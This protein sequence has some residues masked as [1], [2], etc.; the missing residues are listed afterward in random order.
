MTNIPPE[1]LAAAAIER[2]D[3]LNEELAGALTRVDALRGALREAIELIKFYH[4]PEAWDI[5][6]VESPEMKR[7]HAA[8]RS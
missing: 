3:E 8:L 6:D 2:I 5:Y 1:E 7:L 4:G